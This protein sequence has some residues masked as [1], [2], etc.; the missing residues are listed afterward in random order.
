[1]IDGKCKSSKKDDEGDVDE[2]KRS[3]SFPFGAV[4]CRGILYASSPHCME[5]AEVEAEAFE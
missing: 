2:A 3:L 5:K 1:M 4:R